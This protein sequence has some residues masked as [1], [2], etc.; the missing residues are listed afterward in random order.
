MG[1]VRLEGQVAILEAIV[2]RAMR[3]NKHSTGTRNRCPFVPIRKTL[4]YLG[5]LPR[6]A[7]HGICWILLK[8]KE[9]FIVQLC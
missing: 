5:G 4:R 6:L 3:I 7:G 1:V 2:S 8:K 9:L